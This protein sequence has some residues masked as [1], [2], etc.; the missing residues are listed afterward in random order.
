MV[1]TI[2]ASVRRGRRCCICYGLNHDLS[3]KQGQLA[4][5]NRD[6]SDSSA[7]NLAFTCLVHHDWFD[8]RTS[9]SKGATIEEAKQV[10]IEPEVFFQKK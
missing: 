8:T 2:A 7:D 9:Q 10:G 6:P 3:I 4:H 1:R 5:V